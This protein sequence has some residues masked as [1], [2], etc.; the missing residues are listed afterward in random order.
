MLSQDK[1]D[2]INVLARKQ[3]AEGLTDEEKKEQIERI[4]QHLSEK[5]GENGYAKVYLEDKEFDEAIK[6]LRQALSNKEEFIE[7]VKKVIKQ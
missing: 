7:R 1:L 3:R 4:Y 5:Y 6:E 2:R